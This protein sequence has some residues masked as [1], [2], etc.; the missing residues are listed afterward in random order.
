MHKK[1]DF[2]LFQHDLNMYKQQNNKI[3]FEIFL[4][5]NVHNFYKNEP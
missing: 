3:Y 5:K 1:G 4:K 2:C